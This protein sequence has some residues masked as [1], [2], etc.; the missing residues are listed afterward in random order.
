M[1]KHPLTGSRR[2]TQTLMFFSFLLC[3]G[4]LA[5]LAEVEPDWS[6]ATRLYSD[7][8]ARRVG[9]I[10]TVLIVEE[11]ESSKDS[12]KTTDKKYKIGG[13]VSLGSP[14]VDNIPRASWTNAAVPAW[15]VDTA[16][17]FEGKGGMGN[18][19]T[20]SGSIAVRVMEVLPNGNLMIEGKRRLSVQKEDV[21]FILTGTVRPEDISRDNTIKSTF[22]ADA[23]IQYNST[24]SL[25]KN[26]NKGL[27]A[28]LWDWINPF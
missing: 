23:S 11:S 15:S 4:Q 24:G 27:V 2:P 5:A 13:S 12:S 14:T 16:N 26:Q 10:L 8:K 19:D 3:A 1:N 25:A 22:V 17:S 9:D 28:S 21:E 6:A 20:L 18:K 7:K